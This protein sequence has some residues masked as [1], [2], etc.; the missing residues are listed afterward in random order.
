MTISGE[1]ARYCGQ[2]E[3]DSARVWNVVLNHNLH[4]FRVV[5]QRLAERCRRPTDSIQW[6]V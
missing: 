5:R 3:C 6:A 1:A 2:V 4:L